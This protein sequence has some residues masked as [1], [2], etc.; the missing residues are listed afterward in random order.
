MLRKL[1]KVSWLL[2]T[3]LCAVVFYLYS[4]PP[5]K[6]IRNQVREMHP[7]SELSFP[8]DY[9]SL[10]QRDREAG[11]NFLQGQAVT[12]KV[13]S[14]WLPSARFRLDSSQTARMLTVL[15]DSSSY[16]WGE[17]GTSR[18]DYQLF[19]LDAKGETV[20]YADVDLEGEVDCYPYRSVM[21]WGGL[22]EKGLSRMKSI[23]DEAEKSTSF[24][25]KK[26]R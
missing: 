12:A 18:R 20:G 11:I 9:D 23:L 6:A 7:S 22:S 15:N 3:L 8:R 25:P 4:R 14:K 1:K 17:V 2:L 5:L 21:K 13:F 16:R 24:W 10:V 19:F 26:T